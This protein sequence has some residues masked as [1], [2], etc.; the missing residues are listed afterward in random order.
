MTHFLFKPLA[1]RER[2]I[3]FM[4]FARTY[5]IHKMFMGNAQHNGGGGEGG[6]D[7]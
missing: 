3:L 5:L 1:S 2:W 4:S 6:E 7:V